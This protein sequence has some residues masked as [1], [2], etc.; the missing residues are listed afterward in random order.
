[1]FISLSTL[2][3]NFWIHPRIVILFNVTRLIMLLYF[4]HVHVSLHNVYKIS[5]VAGGSVCMSVRLYLHS[6]FLS[7]RALNGFDT[8]Y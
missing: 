8:L 6:Q 2:F 3:G 5:A 1:L 4:Y 7:L